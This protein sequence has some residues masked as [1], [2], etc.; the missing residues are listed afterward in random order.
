VAELLE[1]AREQ[2]WYHTLELPGGETTRGMFDLR[3]YVRHYGIPERL[4]GMRALEVGTWDGFWAFELERRGA[5]VVA[6][7]LDDERDLDWPPR[8]RP[9]TFPEEPR[10]KGFALARELLGSNVDRRNLS[11]YEATPGELGGQFDLVF[12]GSVLLHLRDQLL[13]LE[14]MAELTKPGGLLIS[15]E[16]YDRLAS[17]IPFPVSRYRADREAAVVFWLPAIKTW[18]RMLW[19]AGY[20]DVR[21]HSRF[22]LRAAEGWSVPHVVHHARKGASA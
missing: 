16:E 13:A 19:T 10:G 17:L 22:K 8:R 18:A 5:D 14:H 11:I 4:D 12:C 9:R 3:P 21:R 20:D 6:L 1:R 7:D 2:G 15:A